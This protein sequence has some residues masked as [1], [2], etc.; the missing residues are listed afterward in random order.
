MKI[1]E[2][3]SITELLDS[4]VF[5]ID[6]PD[7]TKKVPA[8]EMPFHVM[9]LAGAEN[10][11]I[12]FRGKNIGSSLTAEQKAHIQD[13][14]FKDLWLG[15]YWKI[16]DIKWR[17]VDFDYWYNCGDTAFMKHHLVIM[18]DTNLYSAQM[19]ISNNTIGGYVASE[20]Y[21][22]NLANAKTMI[23]SAFENA[24]LIHREYLVNAVSNGKPSGGVWR[25]SSVELPNECMMYGHPYFSP[26][27]DGS[28]VPVTHSV[29]KSQLA[30]FMVCPRFICNQSWFWL[31]DVVTSDHFAGVSHVGT[32]SSSSASNAGGVRPVFLVG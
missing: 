28:T 22:S 9:N 31:R 2:Y 19:N 6:G 24:V 20:M 3:P 26:A 1:T 32:P 13:G 17:I 23:D 18:P 14:S 12:I 8:S 30:L 11:R 15:D 27:S 25:D 4:Y 7:G 29:S 16:G 5:V 10:H 21:A